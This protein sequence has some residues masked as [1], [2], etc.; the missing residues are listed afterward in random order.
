MGIKRSQEL[1]ATSI[2]DTLRR[3][4]FVV[5]VAAVGPTLE[6]ETAHKMKIVRAD[7]TTRSTKSIL[8]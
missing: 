3:A 6:V 4:K 2:I 7:F 5:D 8:L 1:E